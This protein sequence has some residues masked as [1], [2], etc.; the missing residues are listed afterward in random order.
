MSRLSEGRISHLAHQIIDR[1]RAEGLAEFPN[2]TKM[3]REAKDALTEFDQEEDRIDQAVRKKIHS[4]S[5]PIPPGSPEWEV[6]YRK[7][8]E[9]E[10]R[11]R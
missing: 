5:R 3:L 6:L 8:L 10:L 1:L 11:K 4:L 9:E 7:Y 2:N